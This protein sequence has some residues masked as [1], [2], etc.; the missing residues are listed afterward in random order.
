M[1][2]VFTVAACFLAALTC[3]ALPGNLSPRT[4]KADSFAFVLVNDAMGLGPVD[5]WDDLRT[6]GLVL[7]AESKT[8][9]GLTTEYQSYTWRSDSPSTALRIDSL[10]V[11]LTGQ[12]A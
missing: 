3:S 5:E 11:F 8:M 7:A 4:G 9:L 1:R 2:N 12:T 10:A 6:F